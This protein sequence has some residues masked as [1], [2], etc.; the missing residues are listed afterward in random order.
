VPGIGAQG[1]DL[2]GVL[3]FGLTEEKTG[4]VINSSRG[5]IYAS[6]GEDFAEKAGEETRKLKSAINNFR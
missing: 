1:G 4:L 3:K 5:I 2:E 6:A